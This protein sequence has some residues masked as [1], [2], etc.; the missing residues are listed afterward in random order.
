MQ[1]HRGS[2]AA[3]VIAVLGLLPLAPVV[4]EADEDVDNTQDQDDD[5]LGELMPTVPVPRRCGI[6]ED[7]GI[8]ICDEDRDEHD[9]D[10]Q[11][12]GLK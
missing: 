5:G 10:Y 7:L 12:D 2:A 8:K 11:L 6:L 9:V 4:S 3:E 1:P